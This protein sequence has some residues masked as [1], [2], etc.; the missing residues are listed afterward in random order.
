MCVTAVKAAISLQLV[1]GTLGM[2]TVISLLQ[3][4]HP[5]NRLLNFGIYDCEV[6]DLPRMFKQ[7]SGTM[8]CKHV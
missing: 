5:G 1:V 4:N 2:L 6:G 8:L 3:E 7:V